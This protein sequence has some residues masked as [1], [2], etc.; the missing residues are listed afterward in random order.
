MKRRQLF[1]SGRI[2]LSATQDGQDANCPALPCTLSAEPEDYASYLVRVIS[3]PNLP[4]SSPF[5]T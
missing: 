5:H 2:R 4:K 1:R 3:G